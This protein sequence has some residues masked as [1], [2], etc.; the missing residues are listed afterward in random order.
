[1]K[2]AAESIYLLVVYLF[3]GSINII[4]AENYQDLKQEQSNKGASRYNNCLEIRLGC[5]KDESPIILYVVP[6]CLHC[7]KFLAEDVSEF[8]KQY[9][10]STAIIVRFIVSE[11]KDIFILKL[12]YNKFLKDVT[13]DRFLKDRKYN[14]FWEYVG[15]MKKAIANLPKGMEEPDIKYFKKMAIEFQFSEEDV[16]QAEPQKE[17]DFEKTTVAKSSEFAEHIAEISGTKEIGTPYIVKND[18]EI[19]NF[20][21]FAKIQDSR[22]EKEYSGKYEER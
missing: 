7:G 19:K 9:G 6:S 8:L 15:Y 22:Q 16:N 14:M 20:E 13:E 2:I 12:F 4:C 21:E 18:K 10:G 1:M 11:A 17:Q 5:T 3:W